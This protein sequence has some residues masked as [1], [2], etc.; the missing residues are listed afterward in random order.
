MEIE[1]RYL[2]LRDVD[3]RNATA[4]SAVRQENKYKSSSSNIYISVCDALMVIRKILTR[5]KKGWN[6][7]RN[8]LVPYFCYLYVG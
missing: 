2:D 7:F 5:L 6:M 8:I 1:L 3:E 4:G